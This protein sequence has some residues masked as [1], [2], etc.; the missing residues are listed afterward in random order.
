MSDTDIPTDTII[1]NDPFFD[2]MG[3]EFA[4][5]ARTV[6]KALYLAAPF[7]K[8]LR[9]QGFTDKEIIDT[10]EILRRENKI[11]ICCDDEQETFWFE[12]VH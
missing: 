5:P 10:A 1:D 6:M 7:A 12:L 11:R 4:N 3:E 9:N 8:L 2:E